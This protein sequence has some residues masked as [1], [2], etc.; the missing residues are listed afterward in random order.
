MIMKT[1]LSALLALSVLAG[2]AAPASATD[3][4]R[5]GDR[6]VGLSSPLPDR[7]HS[8]AIWPAS[9]A[10]GPSL[11]PERTSSPAFRCPRRALDHST[12]SC[13][14]RA[15]QGTPTPAAWQ[16][17]AFETTDKCVLGNGHR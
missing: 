15:G 9:T 13:W 5:N 8:Q 4:N 3:Y 17:V 6:D 10:R 2:I 11:F 1:I 16:F 7:K 14:I 12:A